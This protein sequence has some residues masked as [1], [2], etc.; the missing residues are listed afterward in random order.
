VGDKELRKIKTDASEVQAKY[1]ALENE[2]R[3][4]R[5]LRSQVN[6]KLKKQVQSQVRWSRRLSKGLGL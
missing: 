6:S 5:D 2:I 1:A 3:L 4:L